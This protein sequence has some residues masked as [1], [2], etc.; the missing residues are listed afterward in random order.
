MNQTQKWSK[1]MPLYAEHNAKAIKYIYSISNWLKAAKQKEIDHL[2]DVISR[3]THCNCFNCVKFNWNESAF[4]SL[5]A[6]DKNNNNEFKIDI[7]NIQDK[8][9]FSKIHIT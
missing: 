9:V 4:T 3:K 5:V 2:T 6:N 8:L 7:Y 1:S